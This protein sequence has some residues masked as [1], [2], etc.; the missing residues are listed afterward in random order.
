MLLFKLKENE[1]IL[2]WRYLGGVF[3]LL[4]VLTGCGTTQVN[5]KKERLNML[6]ME[7]QKST[8]EIQRIQQNAASLRAAEEKR[9][10]ESLSREQQVRLNNEKARSAQQAAEDGA[11]TVGGLLGA[12][13]NFLRPDVICLDC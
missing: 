10:F 7:N 12:F 2:N 13:L 3:M 8:A 1:M 4:M 5:E 11:R 9:W 6:Q